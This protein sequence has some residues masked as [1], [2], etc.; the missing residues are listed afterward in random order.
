MTLARARTR[1]RASRPV[2]GEDDVL[3]DVP[4]GQQQDGDD[5]ERHRPGSPPSLATSSIAAKSH[6]DR[7]V[8]RLYWEG[9]R[10]AFRRARLRGC[11]PHPARLGGDVVRP[12]G[13]RELAVTTRSWLPAAA[14]TPRARD[15][16]GL[17]GRRLR[18][19]QRRLGVATRPP[20]PGADERYHGPD[21]GREEPHAPASCSPPTRPP[22]QFALELQDRPGRAGESV[23]AVAE[24]VHGRRPRSPTW[25]A[26]CGGR[27]VERRAVVLM[28][29]LDV[30]AAGPSSPIRRSAPALAPC[31]RRARRR[32]RTRWRAPS[33][34]RSSPAAAPCS[35]ARD[36]R[37]G[38]SAS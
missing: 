31:G 22:A 33:G 30:Q 16:R 17:H 4:A 2:D 19:G 18:A 12:D 34:R 26:P 11:R 6:K 14:S 25:R 24:R 9:A 21:R 20:G 38:G 27:V 29:P 37:C 5:Q 7:A 35:P 3:T 36:R 23:G 15:R 8:Q 28:L 10:V 1:P 32:P 13:Q